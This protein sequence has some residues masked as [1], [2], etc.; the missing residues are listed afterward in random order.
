MLNEGVA[1]FSVSFVRDRQIYITYLANAW[2]GQASNVTLMPQPG[3]G[4]SRST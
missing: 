2:P 3:W 1:E 4:W